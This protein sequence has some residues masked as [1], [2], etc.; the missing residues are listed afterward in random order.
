M[1]DHPQGQGT[2]RQGSIR[3][4]AS[5]S[6]LASG[7]SLTR[8]ARTRIRSKTL[9]G[10]SSPRPINL[11]KDPQ[12]E[13]PYL[14]KAF[15][16]EPIPS[17][18]TTPSEVSNAP[19]RPPRSPHR[20]TTFDAHQVGVDN[21]VEP[22]PADES[23]TASRLADVSQSFPVPV[24]LSRQT[25]GLPIM[26]TASQPQPP[27]S[28]FSRDPS[29]TR[30][31]T[32]NG[33]VRDS[34]STQLSG[35]SSSVYPL[36]TSTASG[37]ESPPSPRSMVEQDDHYD[38]S[39]YDP[40]VGD[41]QEYDADD[42]SYRL[43]LLV[44]NNYFL[45][46]AHSK[47]SLADFASADLHVPKKPA[48]STTPTFLDLFRGKSKSKPTT[49]TGLSP[50]SDA[51]MPALRTAADS[52]TPSYAVPRISSQIP[53]I[54]PPPGTR[55][56]RVVVVREK[57]EDLVVAAKQAEQDMKARG[58]RRDQGSQGGKSIANDVIDPTD[59]VDLPPPSSSYPFAV[60]ASALHGLGVRDSVGAALLADRLPPP[61]SPGPSSY[62]ADDDWR[63]ALL[64]QA[65]HHSLDTT[66]PDASSF[67]MLFGGVSSTPLGS[68]QLNS[69]TP[70]GIPRFPGRGDSPSVNPLLEQ[71]II[72]NPR[73]SSDVSPPPLTRTK[74]SQSQS[75]G[76]KAN[77]S[78]NLA[79]VDTSQR[80]SFLPLR[81]E[82][83]SG[84]LT[85]LTPPPRKYLI[86][87]LYSLS[88]TS[89]HRP[90]PR[91]HSA[92]AGS[93]PATL[94]KAMSTPMLSD[95][96]E[97]DTRHSVLTPP[98][99]PTSNSFSTWSSLRDVVASSSF[100]ELNDSI[101]RG[102]SQSFYSD[103]E[104]E[105]VGRP[106]SSTT[107]SAIDGRPS[108]SQS[109][110]S[111]PSPTASAFQDVLTRGGRY[112][113]SSNR[114]P[115]RPSVDQDTNVVRDSPVPRYSAMS[116][117]PRISSSLAHFALSPPPRTSSFHY[118]AMQ[119]MQDRTMISP[120]LSEPEHSSSSPLTDD[121]TLL[122]TAPEPTTPPLPSPPLPIS[123]WRGNS[124]N[125]QL[126]VEIPSTDVPVALH[127]AP[128]PSSPTSFFDS[129]QSQPNAMDD[130]E[131]S[132]SESDNDDI[133]DDHTK[134]FAEARTRN[135][136]I[137]N[138]PALPRP[139]MRLGNHST[140]YVSQG[141][142]SHA[143]GMEDFKRPIANVPARAQFFTDRQGKS[144]HG[145][146]PP[147]SSFDFYKYTQANRPATAGGEIGTRK[148]RRSSFGTEAALRD[149]QKA[150]ESLRKLDGM[151]IQ[152]M[153]AEKDT[154]KRIAATTVRA[155]IPVDTRF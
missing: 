148:K 91:Q 132:S 13:L 114:Q 82:T 61:N 127:S 10:G 26:P 50:A 129:I 27:P 105:E 3:S 64:H 1:A 152:H 111:Q 51:P 146:G 90:E 40:E 102:T 68:P 73:L 133:D 81:A 151:L 48:R 124:L 140:P 119:A 117:P 6:S 143:Y 104:Y 106:R 116:P 36:S 112:S 110:Y 80:H 14:E 45:P 38:V 33:N 149:N 126:S 84:P 2:Q 100:D 138:A 70:R 54:P 139:L 62:D 72:H 20:S 74:S 87:P 18:P 77:T 78:G 150:Q 96:Y 52:I 11:S 67:S 76:S 89:L 121:T 57:M 35:V 71:R 108:I 101:S 136:T 55:T 24:K 21:S 83:P 141:V 56:G 39:S 46:P 98:P 5:N 88:Q 92:L 135:R 66:S 19:P 109:E 60:Q 115:W 22:R 69:T 25:S 7:V 4:V 85:P 34:L 47:P 131:S 142:E 53:R 59:A 122:I 144:D 44:K 123:E 75:S 86:N 137:S 16:Q 154:I 42:V 113:S 107:F 155:N 41:A 15:V 31:N 95:A 145:H 32:S 65:V 49:P 29:L 134:V 94:R 30:I 17:L 9:T 128:G 37:P 23:A 58:V 63:K 130:L 153:E 118:Q 8:R 93:S 99:L 103:V 43:R 28:A 79:P 97:S 125:R 147:V 12:S 120:Q